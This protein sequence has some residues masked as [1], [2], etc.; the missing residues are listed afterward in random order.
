[1]IEQ[2]AKENVDLDSNVFIYAIEKQPEF[3][4][5]AHRVLDALRQRP[6]KATTSELTLAEVLVVPMRIGNP[7]FIQHFLD[8]FTLSGLVHLLPLSTDILV[9]MARL[10]AFNALKLPDAV[11]IASAHAAG[12]T[13]IVSQDR[14]L[15]SS[16]SLKATLLSDLA[17]P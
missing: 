1:M 16:K 12:C 14:R 4:P 13:I 3:G 2:L 5:A 10:R 7:K 15:I 11:H 9:E 6:S 8:F 17:G